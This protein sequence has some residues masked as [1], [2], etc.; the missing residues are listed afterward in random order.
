MAR[1][2]RWGV[3]PFGFALAFVFAWAGGC[4]S[5]RPPVSGGG[6]QSSGGNAS[7]G[8]EVFATDAGPSVPPGCGTTPDGTQCG[9]LDVPLFGD[10]PTI[11][12]V[13]DRSG[14][15]A[16]SDKWNQVRV[17]IGKIMRSLG[18]RAKFGAAMFPGLAS[19]DIC[20]PGAEILSVRAG[21]APSSGVDGPTTTALLAATRVLPNGGTPTGA[22]LEVVRSRLASAPGKVYVILATDGAPNCNENAKCGFDSCQVN[23]EEVPGCPKEGPLN[24]CEDPNGNPENCND[25]SATLDAIDSLATTGRP[26][27]VVGL[28]GADPYANLLDRMAVAGGTALPTSPRYFAVNAASEPVMLAALKKIAAKITATCTF[29]LQQ[30]PQSATNVNVY[31][32]D[33]VLPYEPVDGWTITDRTVT[34]VGDACARVQNGDVLDVRIIDGCPR[35]EPR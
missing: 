24:C 20:A 22:T 34:L 21:D 23:I 19:S 3:G 7:S 32:D 14:S 8:G 6:S 5:S 17:T 11:Y 26:V 2:K 10:P 25:E 12:F 27:Y 29:E 4:D 30:A 35:I 18:P 9:C 15:M 28:P 33:V 31:L 1:S 13:L 16:A